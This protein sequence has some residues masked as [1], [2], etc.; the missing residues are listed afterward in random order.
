MYA[1]PPTYAESISG[2]VNIG[3]D[4]EEEG[5]QGVEGN[6]TYTPMYTYV[7]DYNYEPP[8]AYSWVRY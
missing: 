3:D 5:G 8:P 7:Y 4:D 1:A 6:W 2:A